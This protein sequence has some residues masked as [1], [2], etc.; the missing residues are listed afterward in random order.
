MS[1]QAKINLK[2]NYL[3]VIVNSNLSSHIDNLRSTVADLILKL[4]KSIRDDVDG[5]DIPAEEIRVIG[6]RLHA[7]YYLILK[8]A[9]SKQI[10]IKAT[11]EGELSHRFNLR[12][13]I[14]INNINYN[15]SKEIFDNAPKNLNYGEPE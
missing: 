10:R 3:E 8:T 14:T 13:P 2:G 12:K 15:I 4:T 1:P 6:D 7:I 5:Y 9:S 11:L